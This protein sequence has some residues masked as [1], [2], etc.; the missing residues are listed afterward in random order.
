MT[1]RPSGG[2]RAVHL[3]RASEIEPRPV[4]WL[5]PEFLAAGKLHLLAGSPGTGKTTIAMSLAASATGSAPWADGTRISESGEVVIWSAE[6]DPEDTLVPRLIAAGADLD[7]VHFVRM[8]A[9]GQGDPHSFDPASDLDLLMN[10]IK[11]RPQV[12]LVIIDPVISA[13]A[14]DSH[15]NAEVRRGLQPLCDLAATIGCAVLG[16]SHYSKGTSERDPV[17]RVTG[18]IA[19]GAAPRIVLCT[20]KREAA[21]GGSSA[22]VLVRAKSNVGQDGGGFGYELDQ[23]EVRPGVS[24]SVVRWSDAID[25]SARLILANVERVESA[26]SHSAVEEAKE[27]LREFLN[28]GPKPSGDVLEA[29]EQAGLAQKTVRRA[30][31]ALGI[32]PLKTGMNG[33]W[34]WSLPPKV[35]NDGE[36]GHMPRADRLPF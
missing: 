28:D 6:D 4:K 32:K 13:I 8:S 7:R 16:I 24:A 27:F 22:R 33:G 3:Q 15:K 11:R 1:G 20:A 17:E 31:K 19:F 23:V 12:T 29:A 10:D 26:A 9:D 18:S 34:T 2:V 35:A 30:Q 36:D 21:V 5:W 14:G 25:G